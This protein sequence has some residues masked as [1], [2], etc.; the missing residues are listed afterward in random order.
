MNI[1]KLKSK[2]IDFIID[3]IFHFYRLQIK[4]KED[5]I[6]VLSHIKIEDNALAMANYLAERHL[7]K[8]VSLM[9][10]SK[11][12]RHRDFLNSK[13]NPRV[14]VVSFPTVRPLNK[15]SFQILFGAKNIFFTH[16]L[17]PFDRYLKNIN[18]IN[19]WHGV[20]HK[21]INLA[22]GFKTGVPATYTIAT[23][24][25]SQAMF[26]D[27]F[28][29][30]IETVK[31]AGLP[32]ND[33]M[34]R[35]QKEIRDFPKVSPLYGYDKLMIWM[36]TF[37]RK[38]SKNVY[39]QEVYSE[40][41]NIFGIEDFEIERFNSMLKANNTL[42]VM[43]SHYFVTSYKKSEGFS[44]ILFIDDELLAK[45]QLLLYELMAWTDALITDYSSV[46]IDY[47]L[48]DQPIFLIAEDLEDYKN[49]QGL[50]FEDYENWVPSNLFLNQHDFLDAIERF[51]S[52]GED[53]YVDKR[54]D[55]RNKYFKYIDDKSAERIANFVFQKSN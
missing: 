54:H 22:R 9:V 50:Y 19:I 10:S 15:E 35:K 3:K 38:V 42:C 16:L 46:M 28:G 43:K 12:F 55:V 20:G 23:S 21:K 30:P 44:N 29:N 37:R 40:V 49:G 39:E 6:V 27:L 48:L 17:F 47:S 51:L 32:R 1:T 52:K 25:M 24:E 31:I 7:D 41:D 11:D 5:Q 18:T 8:K 36:P 53:A 4:P 14:K 13:L 26:A 45:N 34:L 2:T 33:V